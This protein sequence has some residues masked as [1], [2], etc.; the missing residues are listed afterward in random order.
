ML[1]FA[2]IVGIAILKSSRSLRA[3]ASDSPGVFDLRV[4]H[5]GVIFCGGCVT[6][7][8]SN[9]PINRAFF[10]VDGSNFYHGLKSAGAKAQGT[11]SFA[12]IARKLAGPREWTGLR[13][14]VGQM[15]QTD[16]GT[17]YAEQ[18]SF[19]DRQKKLDD[20]ISFHMG[21]METRPAKDGAAAVLHAYVSS[22]PT[23][24]DENIY[25]TLWAIAQEHVD[26][27]IHVEKGVDVMLA[28]DLVVLAE[29]DAYDTA[30]LLSADGDYTHA[31]DFV[32]SKD[33]KIF[34]VSASSGAQLAAHVDSFIRIDANWISD[35]YQ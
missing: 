35:C 12:K 7:S 19:I 11:L 17:L 6:A 15:K 28:V 27:K 4:K 3:T 30:Y 23:R 29:R 2:I 8:T 9:P 33:K 32:R 13:Y 16:N 31:A 34:A 10:F 24:I 1:L 20:R 14:Y 18:R 26:A 25:K 5:A 22:L 21:R